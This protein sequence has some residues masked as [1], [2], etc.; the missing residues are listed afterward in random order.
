MSGYDAS[1]RVDTKVDNSDLGELQKDFNKLEKKLDNLYQKGEKLEAL[2]VDKQSRQWKALVYD[3]AQTEMALADVEERLKTVNTLNEQK[4]FGKAT[5][6]AKKLFKVV[7][8]GSKKS[9]GL[10]ATMSSRLKGIALSLLVFNWITKGFN[11]MVQAMKAGFQNLA[12]YS[13]DYNK[14]MS[15]LKSETAQLKNGLAAS[16]EPIVTT[17]IPYLSRMIS[18][19]NRAIETMGQFLAAMQG[20]SVYT[21]AKKQAIDYAKSL[22]SVS[23]AAK[24]AL[25]SFDQLNVLN[26]KEESGG[27]GGEK[28]GSDAFEEAKIN[29]E[30]Y[31]AL[32]KVREIM[33]IIKPLAIAIGVALLAWEIASFLSGLGVAATAVST[34]YSIILAIGGMVIAVA[35]YFNMWQ[36]DVDW[37]GIIGYVAGLTLAIT[38]LYKLFGPVAAGIATIVAGVAGFALALKDMT[39]NGMNAQN[40]TLL[41]ISTVGIL[42]GVFMAFGS[43][44]A[45]VVGG[46]MAA[47]SAIA[48]M[49]AMAGNGKE[50]INAL[51][52]VCSNFAQFFKKIFA[53]DIEGALDS[54]KNAG[55][56]LANVLVITVESIINCIIKGLNWLIDKIN[57][58][59]FDV[60]DWVPGIGGSKL[61]PN[62][63]RINEVNL[64]RL[65][66]GA[67]IQ[68]GKPFAAILGD[69]RAGQTNIETPIATMV[70]AFKQAMSESGNGSGGNYTFVAQL[71]GRTIFK[72]TIRQ[73]QMYFDATGESAFQH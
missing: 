28:I 51:R 63:S 53:G 18:W 26:S 72:E 32:E 34:I 4:G 62:I 8:D 30:I 16:L 17:M 9:N 56:D 31:T 15:E 54:L 7:N 3:V 59:S 61:S 12:Q 58:I 68:G 70:D 35:S 13:S 44:A 45:V 60:P 55:K 48:A 42:A 38:G 23:K 27:T 5:E 37:E 36:D 69:Q 64:P 52:G 41:L 57:S 25:A 11:A 2:G 43:T 67:V 39:E 65:A 33:E 1:I 19:L 14:A 50:A 24:G 49:V 66:E 20:K 40:M 6:S 71:D 47:I 73:E 21:R 46:I 22:N 29:P 10:L